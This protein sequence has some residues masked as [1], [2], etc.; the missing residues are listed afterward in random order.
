MKKILLIISLFVL[1]TTNA[2][3]GE[4]VT[5][6]HYKLWASTLYNNNTDRIRITEVTIVNPNGCLDPDSYMVLHS[7]PSEVKD[8][9]Y[10]T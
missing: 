7:M 6:I 5:I 3:A 1:I 9:I 10:S 2:L 4:L 8:R